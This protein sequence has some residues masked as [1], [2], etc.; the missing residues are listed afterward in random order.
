MIF[1]LRFNFVATALS[2]KLS[3][4]PVSTKAA[5]FT[6]TGTQTDF[7]QSGIADDAAN[8]VCVGANVAAVWVTVLLGTSLDEELNP[9]WKVIGEFG[10]RTQLHW[11]GPNLVPAILNFSEPYLVRELDRKCQK[12]YCFD[13]Q[14]SVVLWK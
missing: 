4:L 1:I 5:T 3:E 6:S 12:D 14:V 13:F 8:R 10:P 2:L 11:Y 9:K 7:K